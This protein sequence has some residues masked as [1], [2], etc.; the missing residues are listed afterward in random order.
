MER[1]A[2]EKEFDASSDVIFNYGYECCAFAHNIYG[3]K[4]MI[5]AEMPDMSKPL[6]PEFF[7]NPRC[8]PSVSSDLPTVA[9]IR[10]ELLAK[11]P[12]AVVDGINIPPEPP[13]REDEESN[14]A[15]EG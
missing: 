6:P 7:I 13:A 2:M 3:S 14:V 12:L 8:P 5:L 4:S 15:S 9:T 10:E 11:S 1:K